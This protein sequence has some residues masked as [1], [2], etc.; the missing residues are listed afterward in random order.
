MSG[1]RV[2]L[3]TN[4]KNIG[5]VPICAGCTRIR[6]RYGNWRRVEWIKMYHPPSLFTHGLCPDCAAEFE[7]MCKQKADPPE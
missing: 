6:D 7:A 1:Q 4:K 2:I 3:E 5:R